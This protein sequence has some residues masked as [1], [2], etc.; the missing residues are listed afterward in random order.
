MKLNKINLFPTGLFYCENLLQKK[1]IESIKKSLKN[2]KKATISQTEGNLHTKQP[3]SFLVDDIKKLAASIFAEKFY[4]YDHFEITGMW[5]NE[6]KKDMFLAPHG[7]ANNFFA[8]V[9]YLEA[10]KGSSSLVFMDPR[11]QAHLIKPY[12]TKLTIENTMTWT[13]EPQ[14]NTIYLFPAW[15]QH[16]VEAQGVNKKRISISFNIMFKGKVGPNWFEHNEF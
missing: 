6:F 7:H 16:H 11:P 9:Y 4:H 14:S 12:K 13:I 5:A 15:L 3:F 2:Q 8:G 10:P 1:E